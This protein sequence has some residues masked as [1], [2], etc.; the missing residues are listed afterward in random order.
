MPTAIYGQLKKKVKVEGKKCK[1]IKDL[2]QETATK[3]LM[4]EEQVK[5][6]AGQVASPDGLTQQLRQHLQ[7]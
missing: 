4:V 2:Q 3:F 7:A 6:K 1:R 5:V